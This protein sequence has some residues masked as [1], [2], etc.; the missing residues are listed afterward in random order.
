VQHARALDRLV[1]RAQL[2]GEAVL[3]E[4]AQERAAGPRP[5][6]VPGDELAAALGIRP[7]P[8]LGALLQRLEED[9]F[10]GVVSTREQAI[11]RARALQ[12]LFRRR[13][14]RG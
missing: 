1:A 14:R 7:G 12:T 8:E 6:L 11:E 9:R 10:A 2:A 13:R 5:P 4:P 3:L